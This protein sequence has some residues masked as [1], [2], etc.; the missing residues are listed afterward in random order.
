L[1]GNYLKYRNKRRTALAVAVA[2]GLTITPELVRLFNED[3][4]LNL[5][6]FSRYTQVKMEE[7]TLINRPLQITDMMLVFSTGQ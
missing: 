7:T 3:R 2:F 4:L 6:F 1:I 5:P